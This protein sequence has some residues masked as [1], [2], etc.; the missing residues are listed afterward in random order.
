MERLEYGIQ[1][2]FLGLI[3]V[4][5]TLFLLYMAIALYDRFFRSGQ[6]NRSGKVC[7]PE[8][9]IQIPPLH[10]KL[11][12]RIVA[13]IIGA[14]TGILHQDIDFGTV[15]V[16]IRPAQPG[17]ASKWAAAGRKT[18]FEGR[19]ELEKLRRKRIREKI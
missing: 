12:P 7:L 8:E 17:A 6:K 19:L 1:I 4:L 13:T 10:G 5:L 14:V 16:L 18:A 11:P 2:V 3:M 15:N 9:M